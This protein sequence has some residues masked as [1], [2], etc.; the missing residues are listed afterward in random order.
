MKAVIQRVKQAE[1]VVDGRV[2]S[3][4]GQG[5]LT[6]LGVQVGDD[7]AQVQKLIQKIVDLRIFED[8]AGK[9]NRSLLDIS[10][11]HLIVS[12]FTLAGDCSSGRRPSFTTA[13]RPERA[14]S[15]YEYALKQSE[16]KGVKTSAGIFQADMKVG[17]VNDGP[18][19]FILEV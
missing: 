9:M 6:L 2:V 13:E 17:L 5:I 14:K 7:E 8:E 19:T 18:V 15:L 12:Q 3:S 16:E 4:I 11:E 1:V 10:G